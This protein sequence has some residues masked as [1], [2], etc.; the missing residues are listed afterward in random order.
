LEEAGKIIEREVSDAWVTGKVK[1]V[2]LSS[3]E[4]EGAEVQVRTRNKVVTLKGRVRSRE[5]EGKVMA[6][7]ADVV[8]VADVESE[9]VAAGQ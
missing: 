9:L 3:K 7:V 6:L 4:A 5:Q 8:G 2:L 1:A